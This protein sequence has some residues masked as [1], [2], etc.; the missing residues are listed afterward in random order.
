MY[1]VSEAYK[2][3]IMS[4]HREYVRARVTIGETVIEDK[5][6]DGS[7]GNIR[8]ITFE[9]GA[10]EKL[11]GNIV[12][13]RA[14]IEI[15]DRAGEYSGL[16]GDVTIEIGVT[17]P[18]GTVEYV[19][20]SPLSVDHVDTDAR[21]KTITVTAY[22]SM[23]TAGTIKIKGLPEITYPV[24]VKAYLL[25]VCALA[26]LTYDGGDFLGADRQLEG[27]P[28]LS[29]EETA[30][31][32]LESIA[33]A[34]LCNGAINRSGDLSLI[35]VW[36]IDPKMSIDKG[37]MFDVAIN[38][39]YGPINKI[40]LSRDPQNDIVY[41]EDAESI[42]ANGTT[43]LIISNN[44][45]IDYGSTDKR[46]DVI[47]GLFD[48]INGCTM[49]SYSIKWRGDP[50]ADC[51]EPVNIITDNGVSYGSVFGS[52]SIVYNGG[53]T[54]KIS[55]DLPGQA[56]ATNTK[57]GITVRDSVR[58][59][60]LAVNKVE[61]EITSL[62]QKTDGDISNL[63]SQI[64]QTAEQILQQV[65]NTYISEDERGEIVQQAVSTAIQ[66]TADEIT[67]EFNKASEQIDGVAG[68]LDA[69]KTLVQEYI[70]FQGALIELGQSSSRFK[71]QLTNEML[72]FWDGSTRVA[73]IS[74][75]RMEITD[76]EIKKSLTLGKFAFEPRD[77]GSLSLVWKG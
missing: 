30:R 19:P 75:Q 60:E 27:Q 39:Q 25:A 50:A 1:N 16:S 40:I 7:P 38:D 64:Q 23:Q 68:D 58:R 6:S 21:A 46:Q 62:V 31:Q 14:V 67:F 33:E 4:P 49:R 3:A 26:G 22:D 28:N 61:G 34:A 17:L 59:V 5:N 29:G 43:E 37:L 12:S 51:W 20:M 48:A 69:Y 70:R 9:R 74:N 56:E 2:E 71:A 72:A 66:Q 65:S 55:L 45:I 10:G 32:V 76:A 63:Y 41:R 36:P 44:P 47:D 42:A 73:S 13:Q 54:S 15:I 53:I 11:I 57:N 77:S 8:K 18:D 35:P 24:T 52:E